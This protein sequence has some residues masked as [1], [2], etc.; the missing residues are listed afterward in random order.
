MRNTEFKNLSTCTDTTVPLRARGNKVVCASRRAY[1]SPGLGSC[2]CEFLLNRRAGGRSMMTTCL[3]HIM[4]HARWD[5]CRHQRTHERS[6]RQRCAGQR[7]R[8]S[9]STRVP[10]SPTHRAST[11]EP[12]S[13]TL[14]KHAYVSCPRQESRGQTLRCGCSLAEDAAVECGARVSHCA[15]IMTAPSMP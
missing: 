10:S 15:I 1:F 6:T 2:I 13:Q 3:A 12:Q 14:Y 9:R 8:S 5:R 4:D 11:R 7:R